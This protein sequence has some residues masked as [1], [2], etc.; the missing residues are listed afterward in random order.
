[1]FINGKFLAQPV[2]GVQRFASQVLAGVDGLLAS[3]QWVAHAPLVLLAPPAH[4]QALP[5]Y[6]CI[7]VRVLPGKYLHA[8]EQFFLP[9]HTRGSLLLN[10]AGSAPLLRFGQVCT[11]HDTAVFDFPSAYS[12]VFARWYRLLFSVQGRLSRRLLTV[13]QFSKSRLCHHLGV[14]AEKIGVVRGAAD[15]LLAVVPDLGVLG[16]LNI[17]GQRYLLAVGSTNPTK[18]FCRL[19]SAFVGLPDPNARLVVVGSARAGVFSKNGQLDHDDPRI[20]EAGRLDDTE[21]K[22][23]YSHARAFVFPS[24]YE[25]FGLPPLEAMLS[26]CPVLAAQA[27]SIPEVCGSGAAYFDP[28]SEESIRAALARALVDDRWLETLREAGRARAERYSWQLAAN[29][30]LE[31]LALLGAVRRTDD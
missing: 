16:R 23:L 7:Q 4:I 13:S 26:N 10:L 11:F 9:W 2:T 6:R 17:A 31:Q 21:L 12:P 22:A 24:L 20:V 28:Q 25:G 19:I 27:A 15:H 5:T 8:W 14:T 3:G 18:N 1:M 30:L 29:D